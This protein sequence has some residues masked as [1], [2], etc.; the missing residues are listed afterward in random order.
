MF[1]FTFLTF[2]LTTILYTTINA[3]T[4][5]TTTDYPL[6]TQGNIQVHDPSIILYNDSFYL[7]KGAPS[8]DYFKAPAMSGPWTQIGTVLNGSSIITY[9]AG[10]DRPWAPTIFS[11]NESF[12]CFYAVTAGGTR[13]S[14][15]GVATSATMEPGSWTDHGALINTGGGPLSNISPY[16]LSNAIDPSVLVDPVDGQVW[17]TFGSYWTDIWQVP[18]TDDLLSVKDA[19][20]PAAHHLSYLEAEGEPNNTLTSY[21]VDT[22]PQGSRPE[23]GS[24][25]SYK[26]PY[27]YL[28]YAHG[29]CCVFNPKKLPPAGTEYVRFDPA[30]LHCVIIDANILQMY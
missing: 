26:E 4:I 13:N 20:S 1:L 24:W 27:Y 25:I 7:F 14:S 2:A 5:T 15:I 30:M 21:P 18:L 16:T 17:L 11:Y 22:D 8:I 19:Q 23:E 12:Y 28:W 10:I 9:K 29:L 3:Q 6:P